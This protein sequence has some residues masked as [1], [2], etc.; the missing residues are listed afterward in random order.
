[1]KINQNYNTLEKSY[2][3]SR[4]AEKV[5]AYKQAHPEAEVIS[6]GIGDVTRPTSEIVSIV[7]SGSEIRVTFRDGSSDTGGS[8]RDLFTLRDICPWATVAI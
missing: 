1:M 4:V 8:I 3:F 6:L 7:A 2:L 5:A